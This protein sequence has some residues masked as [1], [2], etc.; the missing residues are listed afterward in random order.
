MEWCFLYGKSICSLF[1]PFLLHYSIDYIWKLLKLLILLFTCKLRNKLVFVIY[2][3]TIS[4]FFS[5]Y[6]FH[7]IMEWQAFTFVMNCWMRRIFLPFIIS[8]YFASSVHTKS[9]YVYIFRYSIQQLTA[10]TRKSDLRS[11]LFNWL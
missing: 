8:W 4:D 5:M 10:F 11:F 2:I 1:F 9:A 3:H 6:S 7:P